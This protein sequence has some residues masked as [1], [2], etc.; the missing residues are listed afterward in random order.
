MQQE[1]HNEIKPTGSGAHAPDAMQRSAICH[2]DGPVL[3]LAG[4]GSGKTYVITHRIAELIS[5]ASVSPEEIL[6]LTFTKAAAL[7]MQARAKQL[8]RECNYVNFGTFHSVFYQILKKSGR[9]GKRRLVSDRERLLFI[10]QALLMQGLTQRETEEQTDRMIKGISRIKNRILKDPQPL[11]G[12]IY[13]EYERWLTDTESMDFDD[14]LLLCYRYLSE[15]EAGRKYWRKRFSYVLIDEFQDINGLQY[16]TMKL[17]CERNLFCVG[18]DDQSIYSFRGSDPMI[19]KRFAEEYQPKIIRLS[20]NYRCAKHIVEAA[21]CAI[22]HNKDRFSKEITSFSKEDGLPVV[23]EGFLTESA[24]Q[25]ACV[26]RVLK[27]QRKDPSITQAILLRTNREADIYKRLLFGTETQT[28]TVEDMFSY[29]SFI[30]CGRKRSDFVKIMN[31]PSRYIP[32]AVLT[33]E[34]VDVRK[35][36]PRLSDKPWAYEPLKK[37]LDQCDFAA[38]LDLYGQCRYIWDICGYKRFVK[39]QCEDAGAG[40]RF[41]EERRA[42]EK[43]CETARNYRDVRKLM[44]EMREGTEEDRKGVVPAKERMR[45]Q[46]MTYHASK[47]LEFDKVYLPELNYGKV[48]HGRML[49]RT[50]LE[51]ERRMFYVAMTRA[52]EELFLYYVGDEKNGADETPS[53][54]LSEIAAPSLAKRVR[55][56]S[57][58]SSSNSTLS[59]YSSN[60]SSTASNS[61]SSSM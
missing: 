5:Q 28:T 32:K 20:I 26:S 48:P 43:L 37:L 7:Q 25:K 44:G 60:A 50:E 53:P 8:M 49:T 40:I 34:R 39:K 29:L 15:D 10:R 24:M 11:L 27:E 16:D 46:V 61:A 47:G 59:K 19:M 23:K 52:K 55:E 12:R 58:I 3:V 17:L 36:L 9:T 51:E 2:R 13:A 31:K 14:M 41:E 4:P 6:V 42:F 22:G 21:G 30:N 35:V 33:E 56:T 1:P 18:D 45:I 57:Y 54:F 38:G